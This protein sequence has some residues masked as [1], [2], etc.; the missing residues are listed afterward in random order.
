MPTSYL[1][2]IVEFAATHHLRR[3]DWPV[4]RNIVE[5]GA[6]IHD[7]AHRYQCRVTV[8]GPLHAAAGGVMSLAALDA[9]LDGTLT[10]RLDG[11]DINETLP[12]FADG[13]DLPTGEALAVYVWREL[14]PRL[15]PGVSLHAVRL[16]EGP[17]L[18]AEYF[19]EP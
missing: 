9:L 5:F 2:R 18:Y 3:L 8:K 6:A 1:T 12:D 11:Q 13:R 7:H 4:Q 10:Q 16:Q 19:G 15:P 17:Y 14:A